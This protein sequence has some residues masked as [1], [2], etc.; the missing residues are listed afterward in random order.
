MSP[1]RIL[2]NI[3]PNLH[4][5]DNLKPTMLSL[6]QV[7]LEQRETN[8]EGQDKTKFLQLMR[9]MLKWDPV[10]RSSMEE[11]L[12]DEWIRKELED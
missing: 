5:L 6:P 10:K 12:Q 11:L 3:V 4:R 8:L 2:S 9:K 7:F 1:R